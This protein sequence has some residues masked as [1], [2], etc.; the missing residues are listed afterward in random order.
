MI[1]DYSTYGYYGYSRFQ[2]FFAVTAADRRWSFG[3]VLGKSN[4]RNRLGLY[5]GQL[6]SIENTSPTH[7]ESLWNVNFRSAATTV[8]YG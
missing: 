3:V 1:L 6:Q 2:A 4:G 8:E 5:F 7:P